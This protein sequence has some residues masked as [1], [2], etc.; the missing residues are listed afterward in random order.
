VQEQ[1]RNVISDRLQAP[2]VIFDPEAAVNE[3]V[4]LRCG[5]RIEPD[6]RKAPRG[7]QRRILGDVRV[8]V[9]DKP[10]AKRGQ[11]CEKSEQDEG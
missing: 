10:G 1:I 6:F 11:I 5:T 8:V 9:P 2:Q 7:R 4:I 3:R